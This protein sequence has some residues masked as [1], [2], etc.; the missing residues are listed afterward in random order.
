MNREKIGSWKSE[1]GSRKS[2]ARRSRKTEVGSQKKLE[3]RCW[4][5]KNEI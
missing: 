3:V 1:D 4:K 2:E 5:K